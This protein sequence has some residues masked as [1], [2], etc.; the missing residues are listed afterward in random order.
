MINNCAMPYVV[1]R[2]ITEQKQAP[3]GQCEL[4]AHLNVAHRQ[5]HEIADIGVEGKGKDEDDAER[6]VECSRFNDHDGGGLVGT[7]VFCPEGISHFFSEAKETAGDE[8]SVEDGQSNLEAE[9]CSL[10]VN[11]IKDGTTRF[12]EDKNGHC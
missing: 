3:S 11:V 4:R 8:E 10:G 12:G 2:H 7:D 1:S 6:R 5:K 9:I